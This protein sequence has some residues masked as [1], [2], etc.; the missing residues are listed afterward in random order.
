MGKGDAGNRSACF[1]CAFYTMVFADFFIQEVFWRHPKSYELLDFVIGV[2][3]T[4]VLI[5]L[6]DKVLKSIEKILHFQK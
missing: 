1:F 3:G 2:Y 4:Y 5:K 6:V